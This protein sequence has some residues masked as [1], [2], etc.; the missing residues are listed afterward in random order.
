M[1]ILPLL[2][3]CSIVTIGSTFVAKTVYE[4]QQIQQ[5]MLEAQAGIEQAFVELEEGLEE[6]EN[7][8]KQDIAEGLQPIC[9]SGVYRCDPPEVTTTIKNYLYDDGHNTHNFRCS[10]KER[11]AVSLTITNLDSDHEEYF[12]YVDGN[13]WLNSPNDVWERTGN[14]LSIGS[15]M[16]VF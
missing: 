5:T 15:K 12:R 11:S 10:V 2:G 1:K 7:D 3:L 13:R 14:T 6:I 16:I 4:Y 9:D 8:I